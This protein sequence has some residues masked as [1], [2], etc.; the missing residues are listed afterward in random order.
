MS[1]CVLLRECVLGGGDARCAERD[2]CGCECEIVLHF[3]SV[4]S[5]RARRYQEFAL[6]GR[7]YAD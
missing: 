1:V 2:E 5:K 7:R 6:R 3:E 4:P